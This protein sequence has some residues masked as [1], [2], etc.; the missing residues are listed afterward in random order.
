MR[1]QAAAV[2]ASK[3][4]IGTIYAVRHDGELTRFRVQKVT[5]HRIAD[6]G[7]PNDYESE[8]TG[9]FILGK[10]DDGIERIEKATIEPRHLLGQFEEY[11][12]LVVKKEAE[13]K[14]KQAREKI[15]KQDVLD[16]WRLLYQ[17]AGLQ[18]PNDPSGFEAPFRLSSYNVGGSP[19][20]IGRKGVKPLLDGLRRLEA[21]E[22]ARDKVQ[23]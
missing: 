23:S 9:V 18:P 6:N 17:V 3:A 7:G 5:T 10:G 21:R 15:E 4:K 12:E 2:P 1:R 8:I 20:D 14:A 11:E 13:N 22:L 19:P 16:L